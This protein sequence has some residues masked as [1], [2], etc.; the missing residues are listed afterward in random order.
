MYLLLT[1]VHNGKVNVKTIDLINTD[2]KEDFID[3]I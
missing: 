2:K 3:N 1:D